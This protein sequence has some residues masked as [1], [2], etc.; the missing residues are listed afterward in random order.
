L[1]YIKAEQLDCA[2][3]II[4][5]DDPPFDEKYVIGLDVSYSDTTACGC[6]T[7]MDF[8]S[9]ELVHSES[10]IIDC[11][12]AYIPGFFF[13]REGPILLELLKRVRYPGPV[14]I[15]GNG[16][17]HPRRCGLASHVGLKTNRQTIGIAKNLLLGTIGSRTG[18][19]AMI[20]ES[21]D[22]LGAALWLTGKKNP[23]FV[24]IGHRLALETAIKIVK[25]SSIF[26]YPEPLRHA[27]S[28]AKEFQRNKGVVYL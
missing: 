2:K 15:D 18:D 9:K 19:T 22:A 17:L 23:I 13:L 10:V 20:I 4:T 28:L 25:G 24:S 1:E 27:H 14:L 26:G 11:K 7:V 5:C 12:T 16:I 8:Q 6:A 21:G 3:R